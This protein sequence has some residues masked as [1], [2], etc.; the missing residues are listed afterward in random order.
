MKKYSLLTI[1]FIMA[2][3][4]VLGT[5]TEKT[6]E[7]VFRIFNK[8]ARSNQNENN[9]YLLIHSDSLNIHWKVAS[10][11]NN[12]TKTDADQ[13][14]HYASI[15]KTIVSTTVAILAEQGKIKFN[16]H[17]SKYLDQEILNGLHVYKKIDYSDSITIAQLLNHTSG[18]SDYYTDKN[19]DGICLMDRMLAEPD[20]FWTPYATIAWT[21]NNLEPK[22]KPGKGCHYSDTNYE[23]LGLIIEK[24]TKKQLHEVCHELIFN[25]L[26]M[27]DT[28]FIFHSEPKH[29]PAKKM[30]D[31]YFKGKNIATYKSISMSWGG[32][33]II[34]TTEDMLKFFKALNSNKLV[35]KETR[36]IMKSDYGKLGANMNYGY[37]LMQFR[38]FGMG[39]K[40]RI[41]G[42]SGSVGAIMY[43]NDASDTYIIGSF[44]KFGWQVQPIMFIVRTLWHI[45]SLK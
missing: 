18:I 8:M 15:G 13:P 4:T 39:P 45:N 25:P 33:G 17:I 9:S 21:K 7:K 19:K 29:Q 5:N 40:Y 23:L 6:K 2:T 28:Y 41:W 24:I 32:G 14:F 31:L 37:G 1:A 10:S 3:G 20:T 22:F 26:E 11:A 34:C 16:D 43:Y 12:K 36:E 44:N 42:N 35:S 30:T 27:N 38:F